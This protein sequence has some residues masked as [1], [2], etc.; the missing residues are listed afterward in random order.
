MDA[1]SVLIVLT[2]SLG[3]V[4][5]ALPLASLL[6]G[7]RPAP[8]VTWLVD[9]RW[10]PVVEPHPAVS[11]VIVFPRR[12]TA[13]SLTALWRALRAERYDITLDLQRILKSGILGALS[14][15]RRRIGF[16]AADTKELNHLFTTER[17]RPAHARESKIRL[18]LAFVET[19]GL[20][21]PET[22]DFGLAGLATRERLP[23]VLR[24]ESAPLLGVVV[25]S[26]WPSKDWIV[27]GYVDLLTRVS[28]E[29]PM[30]S[31]LLGT[32][33]QRPAA[34]RIADA[35]PPGRIANLV[36]RTS[37]TELA[38]VLAACRAA[39]GPDT[40]AG[41]LAAAVGTPYVGLFGPTDPR[42]V[43]PHGCEALVV[44]A[45]VDCSPCRRRRCRKWGG[46]CMGTITAEAVWRTLLHVIRSSVP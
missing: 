11:K 31:V 24:S 1:S 5:R 18:Y 27:E 17:I 43:A 45:G 14:R 20:A 34:D 22:L 41:H 8:R 19:L 2:G 38:A 21:L 36:G 6:G 12:R 30:R 29:T 26:S 4:V 32:D 37:L 7:V 15:A 42:V 9:E 25:G 33:G 40:G 13:A 46:G 10:A 39:V 44:T 3:D 16:N 28:A 23:G 35:L